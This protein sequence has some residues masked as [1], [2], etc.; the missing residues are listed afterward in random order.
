MATKKDTKSPE[1]KEDTRVPLTRTIKR[2]RIVREAKLTKR[3]FAELYDAK[4]KSSWQE[5]IPSPATVKLVQDEFELGG[6]FEM[7]VSFQF[8]S[9][10]DDEIVECPDRSV[11]SYDFTFVWVNGELRVMDSEGVLAAVKA[12]EE[13]ASAAYLKRLESGGGRR[14]RI[15]QVEDEDDDEE[16]V[17][18]FTKFER[19]VI[20]GFIDFGFKE[21]DCEKAP[22][23]DSGQ[24]DFQNQ[25]MP[26]VALDFNKLGGDLT[27]KMIKDLYFFFAH[28]C[29]ENAGRGRSKTLPLLKPFKQF[30]PLDVDVEDD[31]EEDPVSGEEEADD[32]PD[33][34]SDSDS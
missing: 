25:C 8:H 15:G 22:K 9:Y 30:E 29:L 5:F 11:E 14:R 21:I 24:Y 6:P 20:T 28:I 26:Y 18:E 32:G 27:P 2:T 4:N 13:K 17:S 34:Q 10:E 3:G 7:T 19:G 31:E 12:D 33:E 23:C 1:V 16:R